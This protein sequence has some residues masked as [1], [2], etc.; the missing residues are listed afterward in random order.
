MN[1]A[2]RTSLNLILVVST[3][4]LNACV[5]IPREDPY[6]K[7]REHMPRS[8]LVFP[9]VNES[10]DVI[11]SYSWLSTVTRPIAER[12]YYVY[13]VA[14]VDE[15]MKENGLPNPE[16]MHTAP[17]DKISE[18]FGA[19]AVLYVTI[20]DYGQK[21]RLVS[22]DSVVKARAELVD[23]KTG[24]PIWNNKVSV[25]QSN[26]NNSGGGL[27]GAIVSAAIAQVAESIGDAAHEATHIA[28]HQM[29]DREQNGLLFGPLHPT[30]E[31]QQLEAAQKLEAAQQA[32]QEATDPSRIVPPGDEAPL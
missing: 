7:F 30:F 1:R 14:I 21:F 8:I 12:G 28:H 22:S 13:P 23:V 11:A 25:T 6:I 2:T 10:V 26:S 32:E 18:I 19:E 17:L 9:P 5:A 15:F 24:V 16:D 31:Q 4:L 29:F 20:E 3:A 27:L